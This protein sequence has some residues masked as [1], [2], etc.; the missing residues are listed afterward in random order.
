MAED[1]LEVGGAR[2]LAEVTDGGCESGSGEEEAASHSDVLLAPLASS[3]SV[4]RRLSPFSNGSRG[5][6]RSCLCPADRRDPDEQAEARD[7][8]GSMKQTSPLHTASNG[9]IDLL[10]HDGWSQSWSKANPGKVP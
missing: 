4:P 3:L 6:L 1:R 7:I 9:I 5:Q 8:L 2:K 10:L